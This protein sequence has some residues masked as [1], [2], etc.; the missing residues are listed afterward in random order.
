M[1][2]YFILYLTHFQPVTPYLNK[3]LIV[4]A[5]MLAKLNRLNSNLNGNQVKKGQL[6]VPYTTFY[7]P[8]LAEK[9][10]IRYEY[11]KWVHV[12]SDI[13]GSYVSIYCCLLRVKFVNLK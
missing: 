1:S 7:I 4:A 12:D 13:A 11:M 9:I 8:Q 2:K 3:G 5:S 6:K 10:D